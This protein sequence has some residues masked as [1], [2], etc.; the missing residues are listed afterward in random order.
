MTGEI[1]KS[2]PCCENAQ[3]RVGLIL[4]I[5]VSRAGARRPASELHLLYAHFMGWTLRSVGALVMASLLQYA[6]HRDAATLDTKARCA[7][8][9]AA[10]IERAE[11][12]SPG[13]VMAHIEYGYNRARNACMCS[14]R[15][16]D[17]TGSLDEVV[18]TTSNQRLLTRAD[19][20]LTSSDLSPADFEAQRRA[21]MGIAGPATAASQN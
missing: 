18:D 20:P 1:E 9:G 15:A 3:K 11:R 14:F 5:A 12:G 17:A 7:E 2:L 13:V 8:L 4:L 21:L 6:C 10:Y 16:I 19:P